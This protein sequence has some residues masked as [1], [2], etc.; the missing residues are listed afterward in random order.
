MSGCTLQGSLCAWDDS[1]RV[2]HDFRFAV[3]HRITDITKCR[4][5]NGCA[6]DLSSSQCK[7]KHAKR[8]PCSKLDHQSS[9]CH[10][11]EHCFYSDEHQRCFHHCSTATTESQ[12][13]LAELEG[14]CEWSRDDFR[15]ENTRV[16]AEESIQGSDQ[17]DG[18]LGF[19]GD[20]HGEDSGDSL[21]NPHQ[22]IS[23]L[24]SSD[25]TESCE[26]VFSMRVCKHNSHC[27][28]D[29]GVC[30]EVEYHQAAGHA[31]IGNGNGGVAN[32]AGNGFDNGGGNGFD[33]G[34]GNGLETGNKHS[35]FDDAATVHSPNNNNFDN[36]GHGN[37]ADNGGQ[38]PMYDP[39]KVSSE[40]G[41]TPKMAARAG[42]SPQQGYRSPHKQSP[43]TPKAH[44]P[45]YN[46][47]PSNVMP[48]AGPAGEYHNPDDA[49]IHEAHRRSSTGDTLFFILAIVMAAI[50]MAVAFATACASLYVVLGASLVD[51]WV[52]AAFYW[53]DIR[54]PDNVYRYENYGFDYEAFQI[55]AIVI[56][57]MAAA[58]VFTAY[59]YLTNQTTVRRNIW[60]RLHAV[61]VLGI[62]AQLVI[63]VLHVISTKHASRTVIAGFAGTIMSVAVQLV[64]FQKRAEDSRPDY[65]G[66]S[67][68]SK[69]SS[70]NSRKS[71]RRVGK[72]SLF[73]RAGKYGNQK[74]M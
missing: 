69:S 43:D 70:R 32:G 17:A 62:F 65:Q 20:L 3:C 36:G 12:C 52:I 10:E 6:Y 11:K 50:L 53:V 56:I 37:G 19:D 8:I 22:K 14:I 67:T 72:R 39:N 28:W 54:L 29:N 59:Y 44:Q 35:S 2:C 63:L 31:V 9:S 45:L 27:S 41:N 30:M 71:N 58:R 16:N 57:A 33:N 73:G 5:Y 60:D 26:S 64:F 18:N 46:N 61:T 24:S 48:Q 51:F 47:D 25:S 34:A 49:S 42:G 74:Q 15:C 38:D 23:Q 4:N 40:T 1:D 21:H 68:S 55:T 7:F 13:D 66:V